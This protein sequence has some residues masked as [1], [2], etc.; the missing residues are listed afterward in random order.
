MQF[1]VDKVQQSGN[2][3]VILT[4]RVNSFGYSDLVVYFLYL[5]AMRTFCVP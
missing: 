4:D 5:P 2:P 3:N 1:A